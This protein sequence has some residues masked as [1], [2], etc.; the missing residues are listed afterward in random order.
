MLLVTKALRNKN[1]SPYH[2]PHLLI[3]FFINTML[4]QYF[5]FLRIT[6][7][8]LTASTR[9]DT[10][11]IIRHVNGSQKKKILLG[12]II[13]KV[14]VTVQIVLLCATK[15]LEILVVGQ[16]NVEMVIVVGGKIIHV[17]VT[18]NFL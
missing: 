3:L 8:Q 4:I 9:K 1:I 5:M 12:D 7:L 15:I 16:S 18:T 10:N 2:D 13:Q 17:T 14:M 11:V 6:I